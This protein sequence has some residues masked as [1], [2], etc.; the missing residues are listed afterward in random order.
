[1]KK[2]NFVGHDVESINLR[3]WDREMCKLHEGSD[4]DFNEEKPSRL[5]AKRSECLSLEILF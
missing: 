4:V 3:L 5:R 1:M 2:L